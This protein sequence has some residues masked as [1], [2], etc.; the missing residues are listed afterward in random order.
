MATL[1]GT[2]MQFYPYE[3]YD[4][5]QSGI[6]PTITSVANLLDPLGTI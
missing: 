1:L 2:P 6:N 5:H 4:T 3:E